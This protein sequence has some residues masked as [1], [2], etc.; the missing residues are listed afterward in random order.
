MFPIS[1]VKLKVPSVP[2]VMGSDYGKGNLRW[3][4]SNCSCCSSGIL[5]KRFGII[6]VILCKCLG[7]CSR[8]QVVLG[9]GTSWVWPNPWSSS[10]V[11]AGEGWHVP[12][13][14]GSSPST[15]VFDFTTGLCSCFFL[16]EFKGSQP[17]SS[18]ALGPFHGR[19]LL[20]CSTGTIKHNRNG[21]LTA[22]PALPGL[23]VTAE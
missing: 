18:S 6:R 5:G 13:G 10:P 22:A 3:N 16:P 12:G 11:E 2:A 19:L 17:G 21:T 15:Q 9:Q 14:E 23:G 1:Q 7:G 20:P 8:I 4:Y